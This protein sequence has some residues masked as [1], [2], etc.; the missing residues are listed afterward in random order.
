M[1]PSEFF[2]AVSTLSYGK[3][4]P[5]AVYVFDLGAERLPHKLGA[6]CTELRGK[7]GISADFNVLKF[8][9]QLPK[10]SFLSYPDFTSAPHPELA[11]AIIVNLI[12]GRVRRDDYR[13]RANPPILHR[14]EAFL[15]NDHPDRARFAALTQVEESSGLLDDAAGIGFKLN[16]ERRLSAKGVR[17]SGH[18]LI[19][20]QN[21]DE[22]TA[23]AENTDRIPRIERHRTAI[24]RAAF[25]KPVRLLLD[26]AQLRT[27]ERV[28]DYGC[29]LGT[30]V[31]ALQ[32]LG[33]TASG[34]DPVHAPGQSKQASDVVNL[35]YVLNVIED[36]AERVDVLLR[37]WALAGRLL[38]VSTLVRGQEEY[39]NVRCFGDGVL[40]SRA[41]F[42]KY[43]EPTELQA[44]VEDTLQIDAV[45]VA[46]GIYF[47]F[48]QAEDMQDF[49]SIR[50]KRSIDWES[51]SR[52]LS[53]FKPS[54]PCR[55][56]YADHK[57]LLDAFWE[58]VLT[59]GRLPHVA[60][61]SRLEQVRLACGSVPKAMAL[62]SERFG[63]KT[64]DVAHAR[65]KEDLLV[66]VAATRLRQ[67][68]AFGQLSPQLQRDIRTFFGS[69]GEAERQATELMFAAGDT[70]EMELAVQNL[71][72]GVFDPVEHHYTV[73]R[74]LLDEL[75]II[76]RIYVECGARL[77]GDPREAD[78][79]KFHLRSRKLT[80]QYYEDFDTEPFPA[81]RLRIK[82][83]L[84]RMFVTVFD[85]TELADRQLLLFK[86]R[87]FARDH[88]GRVKLE[89]VSARLRKLGFDETT[90]G[91]GPRKSEL[92][93]L[94]ARLRLT[95]SLTRR[96]APLAAE[97]S[98]R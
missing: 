10:I 37:A 2:T 49:L 4:L 69:F 34:W 29:G 60:E 42:Q 97:D 56:P 12:S 76:L 35:G 18:E 25:S 26:F 84:P 48:R 17:F 45:P 1:T 31:E 23:F 66:H 79:I 87:F 71:G 53:L 90:V 78:L 61:F 92:D 68:I 58:T 91:F 59:L 6:L 20:G 83:D 72:F 3:R 14:K 52:R 36:P 28:F 64:L 73:H 67:R 77:F 51:L 86:E 75:P 55:D 32:A 13:A 33:Y 21:T 43:F 94:R 16:W 54:R 50:A 15:P 88:P 11:A 9:T 70:D 46:M 65:R 62:F 24:L 44:L 63:Q 5:S 85:H 57:E 93:A 96:S 47:V 39:T 30:D 8:H 89:Q 81:L 19:V 80:F 82:I 41:T 95:K 7:I 98:E 38:V 27:G 40:T 22:K 74:S